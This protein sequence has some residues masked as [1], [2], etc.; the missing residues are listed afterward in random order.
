MLKRGSPK[1][2]TQFFPWESSLFKFLVFLG[3]SQNR[4][5]VIEEYVWEAGTEDCQIQQSF[6]R[7]SLPAKL[8]QIFHGIVLFS[9]V[10]YGF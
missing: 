1:K 9:F 4:Y 7:K 6:P 8:L 2:I 10:L 5:G 3:L